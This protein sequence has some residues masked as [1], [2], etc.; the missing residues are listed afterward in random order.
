MLKKGIVFTFLILLFSLL[1]INSTYSGSNKVFCKAVESDNYSDN[2]VLIIMEHSDTLNKRFTLDDFLCKEIEDI[3]FS[4][5][6]ELTLD[7]TNLIRR[8]NNNNSDN[9]RRIFKL[10]LENNDKSDVL[11]VIRALEKRNDIYY[12]GVSYT[13]NVVTMR[14]YEPEDEPYYYFQQN[15]FELI[16][17]REAWG[18]TQGSYSVKVGIIDTGIY[19]DHED[20]ISQVM[21]YENFSSGLDCGDDWGHG[22]NVAGII[23][24][25]IN[26]QG[27]VGI[28]PYVSLYSIKIMNRNEIV[29][30]QTHLAERTVMALNYASSVGIKVVN[31]SLGSYGMAIDDQMVLKQAIDNYNGLVVCAAGNE[32]YDLDTSDEKA[33]PC[34]LN[35]DN[36]ITVGALGSTGLIALNYEWTGAQDSSNSFKYASNYGKKYVDIFAPGTAVF[37][38]TNDGGYGSNSGTSFAAPFVTG[39]C[40]LLMSKYPHISPLLMKDVILN[41]ATKSSYFSDKCVSGG[42]LNAYNALK[43]V[44]CGTAT[45]PYLIRCVDDL[46]AIPDLDNSNAYFK[47]FNNLD[48][49]QLDNNLSTYT[50]RGHY[51]GNGLYLKNRNVS[52]LN[53]FYQFGGLFGV[54][55]G[56]IHDLRIDNFDINIVCDNARIGG[57]VSANYGY[58]YNIEMYNCNIKSNG[59]DTSIGILCGFQDAEDYGLYSILLE[60]S[61]VS[62]KYK[63]GGIVGECHT[64]FLSYLYLN[65]VTINYTQ[66]ANNNGRVGALCGFNYGYFDHF[67][68]RTGTQINVLGYS[69]NNV[70]PCI[71]KIIGCNGMDGQDLGNS[72]VDCK[73]NTGR[74]SSSLG[75]LEYV[76]AFSNGLIGYDMMGEQNFV[77]NTPVPRSVTK[78]EYFANLKENFGYNVKGSCSYV[79]MEMYLLYL[80]NFSDYDI[81]PDNYIIKSSSYNVSPGSY[82]DQSNIL[83]EA[84]I[85]EYMQHI[86]NV[87]DVSLHA[88]LISIG[89]ELGYGLGIGSEGVIEIL[90]YY[91]TNVAKLSR[92]NYTINYHCNYSDNEQWVKNNLKNGKV[93]LVSM[94][95]GTYWSYGFQS[96]G[97]HCFIAYEYD[98]KTDTVYNHYGYHSGNVNTYRCGKRVP[99]GDGSYSNYEIYNY[100]L[101]IDLKNSSLSHNNN[102]IFN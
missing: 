87:D 21:Y 60:D 79:A 19:V 64:G 31:Y 28:S 61:S 3:S 74:L 42:I 59:K 89:D 80:D 66:E 47:Q 65:S 91:L 27:I 18:I 81:I 12:T 70:K 41:S 97:C 62:G 57:L 92:S 69:Y 26:E 55:N 30:H 100:G 15:N 8:S 39:V 56:I 24:A 20:Y 7:Q 46:K 75:Q 14:D 34:C 63:V 43:L 48:L 76:G 102:Y 17:M 29:N 22:T 38:T 83:K 82:N 88:K 49:R 52:T 40:A 50:F 6:S 84:S 53:K 73:I 11:R 72:F 93:V 36:I 90:N 33:Y 25:Q 9:Y 78:E 85:H 67:E 96:E 51:D 16:H 68:V 10:E 99:N 37:S 71:G 13:N 35:C 101:T 32:G 1:L 5:L 44:N 54:N 86:R 4:G 95:C 58:M 45:N 77:V 94:D 98:T 2:S 23:G